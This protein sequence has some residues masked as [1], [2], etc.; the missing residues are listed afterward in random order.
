MFYVLIVFIVLFV[1]FVLW[2]SGLRILRE[3]VVYEMHDGHFEPCEKTQLGFTAFRGNMFRK[4]QTFSLEKKGLH[5]PDAQCSV[6]ITCIIRVRSSMPIPIYYTPL[7]AL[8]VF[9]FGSIMD[10]IYNLMPSYPREDWE[11]CFKPIVDTICNVAKRQGYILECYIS[12]ERD[13]LIVA[14]SQNEE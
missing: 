4:L 3:G 5:N 2:A 14:Y 1:M 10:G 13:M 6:K 11:I 7:A 12:D 9:Y 8:E